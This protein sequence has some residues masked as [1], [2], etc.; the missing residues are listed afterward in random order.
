MSKKRFT[1]DDEENGLC[2]CILVDGEEMP[3]CEICDLLNELSDENEKLRFLIDINSVSERKKLERQVDEQQAIINEQNEAIDYL[4]TV[5][6]YTL[7]NQ[8]VADVFKQ[9]GEEYE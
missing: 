5:I 2:R 6:K 3:T 1:L 8:M 4:K 7:P 9:I